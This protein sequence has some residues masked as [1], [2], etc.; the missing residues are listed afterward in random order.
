MTKILNYEIFGKKNS[1]DPIIICHGLLGSLKNWYSVAKILESNNKKVILLDM[2]N[3]G[4]SFWSRSHTYEEMSDDILKIISKYNQRVDLIGH[5]MGGKAAM[6]FACKNSNFLKKLVIIDI[7]PIEYQ[8]IWN[9]LFINLLSYNYNK[10]KKRGDL[11]NYL[12]SKGYNKEFCLFISQ[13]LIKGKDGNYKLKFNLEAI[14]KNLKNIMSF[15]KNLDCFTGKTL[16]LRGENSSY[17][18][19]EN[20]EK[21]SKIFPNFQLQTIKNAGHWLHYQQRNIF[22]KKLKSFIEN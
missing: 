7:A 21:I 13:N 9:D 20:R 17:V 22:L 12:L 6:Y 14:Y 18:K 1:S 10:V 11:E 15:P 2:R 16:F 8:N 3:H 19:S 4:N 5:S